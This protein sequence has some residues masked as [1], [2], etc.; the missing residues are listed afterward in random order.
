MK[1]PRG[2][3]RNVQEIPPD[4]DDVLLSAILSQGSISCER[5]IDYSE[6]E[7]I[8]KQFGGK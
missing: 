3:K 7:Q 4:V 2:R 5:K 6:Y 1:W 8:L